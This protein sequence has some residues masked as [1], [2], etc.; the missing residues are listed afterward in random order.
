MQ[1]IERKFLVQPEE[2]PH[3]LG[4]HPAI[5]ILQGYL[6]IGQDGTEVRLRQAGDHHFLTVK[7]SGGLVRCEVEIALSSQQFEELWP[8]TAGRRVEKV[9]RLIPHAGMTIEL[10]LYRGQ[11]QGLALAEVEFDSPA[12]SEGF[13]PPAWFGEDVTQDGRYK[14]KNLAVKGFPGNEDGTV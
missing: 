4:T 1:E 5:D 9:R 3:D 2:L 14:N 10:D 12:A 6:A 13:T 8:L 7:S 11:L